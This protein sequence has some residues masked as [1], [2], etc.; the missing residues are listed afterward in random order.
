MRG[1]HMQGAQAASCPVPTPC[2]L[3]A[4]CRDAQATAMVRVMHSMNHA[5]SS[6]GL[7][8]PVLVNQESDNVSRGAW[9]S[10]VDCDG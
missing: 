8:P 9:G 10:C 5:A 2:L 1:V 7:K 4:G 6:A 3:L